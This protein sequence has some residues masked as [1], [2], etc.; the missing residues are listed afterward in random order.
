MPLLRRDPLVASPSL[1][2][3]PNVMES[4]FKELVCIHFFEW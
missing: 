1:V 4:F 3:F 2:Y